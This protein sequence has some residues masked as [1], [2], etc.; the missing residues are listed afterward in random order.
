MVPE[1]LFSF[2]WHP[3][4]IGPGVDY[5]DEPPTLVEFRL[6]PRGDGTLLTVTESGFDRIPAHRRDGLPHERR[7]LDRAGAEHQAPCRVTRGGAW[8]GRAGRGALPTPRWC[9]RPSATPPAWR[10]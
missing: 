5:A 8:R 10:W 9:S 6:E 3:Y 1:R 4:A 7:R 2:T